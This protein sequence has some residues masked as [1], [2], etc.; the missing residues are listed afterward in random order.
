M[1]HT[2]PLPNKF[3]AER[4]IGS[5][6]SPI[7]SFSS[8]APRQSMQAFFA[9]GLASV[10]FRLPRGPLQ[11]TALSKKLINQPFVFHTT[12]LPNKFGA[13]RYKTQKGV[14]SSTPFCFVCLCGEGGIRRS[15]SA[16]AREDTFV[17]QVLRPSNKLCFILAT[18]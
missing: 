10:P 6:R 7:S 4:G 8:F 16:R 12:P 14:D 3:G 1:F 9:L 2:S 17:A 11:R 13:E 15:S 5:L 18:P